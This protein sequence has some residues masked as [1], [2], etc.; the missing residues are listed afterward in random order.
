MDLPP[1]DLYSSSTVIVIG[2]VHSLAQ[3]VARDRCRTQFLVLF[4]SI[5]GLLIGCHINQYIRL[6]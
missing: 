2:R 5:G 1:G 4:D 6:W 3:G